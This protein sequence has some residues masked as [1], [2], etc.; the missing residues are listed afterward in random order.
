MGGCTNCSSKT[1]CSHRKS[2]M[3][4]TID[5]VLSAHYPSKR[6]HERQDVIFEGSDEY[7]PD[8]ARLTDMIGK[9]LKAITI[10]RSGGDRDLC[11]YIDVLCFGR[12]PSLLQCKELGLPI[13]EELEADGMSK[14]I[15]LRICLS[16]LG[17]LAAVQQFEVDAEFVDGQWSVVENIRAGVFDAPLLKRMRGVVKILRSFG[18]TMLDFGDIAEP[19]E[20]Y[21]GSQ[22]FQEFGKKAETVNYLF[23]GTPSE[24]SRTYLL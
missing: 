3:F 22:F 23:Y 11:D 13:P 17:S 1:G 16:H 5:G 19:L 24:E 14:E 15:Y 2:D 20:G 7:S 18:L 21:D 8:L 10:A 12:E 6:W 4:E 9:E